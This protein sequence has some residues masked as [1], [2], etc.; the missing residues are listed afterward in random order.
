MQP[1]SRVASVS[2]PVRM[3][4]EELISFSAASNPNP[5]LI[6]RSTKLTVMIEST[7]ARPPVPIPSLKIIW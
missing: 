6:S 5:A 4:R 7:A 2:S 1:M 3:R